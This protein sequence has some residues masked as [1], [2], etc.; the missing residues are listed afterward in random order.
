MTK[1]RLILCLLCMVV[2]SASIHAQQYPVTV[3]VKDTEI[4]T[5]LK[6]IG[7]QTGLNFFYDNHSADFDRKVSLKVENEEA[8]DVVD[9]ILGDQ[10]IVCR[11][12]EGTIFLSRRV[13]EK[14]H[15]AAGK[16]DGLQAWSGQVTDTKGVPLTGVLL[17]SMQDNSR[18][19]VTDGE[20]KF[21]IS[22]SP[23]ELIEISCL[24]YA[25]RTVPAGTELSSV[26]LED[27]LLKLD[28]AIVV[29]YGTQRRSDVTGAI[30][31]VKAEELNKTPTTNIGEM[32][33]G[34]AAGVQVTLGSA[35]PGGTSSII[36]R[37]RRS[38]SAD[39]SPLYI[40][41]GIPMT[42]IDDINSNDIESMEI[43]K[44]ASSQAIYGARAANGVILI[45]TKRGKEGVTTVSYS[46][47]FAVQ[48]FRR[49]FEFYNG[50]EWAAYRKEAYIQAY[51]T[52]DENNC[53]PGLMKECLENGEYV[54][55]ESIMFKKAVQ[56]KHDASIQGGNEK[57]RY[58]LGLGY[59]GQDGIVMKSGL[60]KF[61]KPPV[62]PVSHQS[63]I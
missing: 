32:L 26:V 3:D 39:N 52:Y 18:S 23:G 49:N 33:R 53:F 2:F 19:A 7:D 41:D 24:G 59:Y 46:G 34:A 22:A 58:A 36:I 10:G 57:A 51:G 40:V 60:D 43:L 28:D 29:G 35:A 12:S 25:A 27:D 56:H 50:E 8:T 37:G 30:A 48:D 11:L 21:V 15:P 20:G 5:V 62:T 63:D 17:F 42:S 9:S 16:G 45:T 47:Y 61:C 54:D 14:D 31:S 4:R 1:S 38:L 44:D 13:A 55:W 6:I